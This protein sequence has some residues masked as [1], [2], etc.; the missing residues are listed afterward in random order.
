MKNRDIK[1]TDLLE[2]ANMVNSASI[3]ANGMIPQAVSLVSKRIA[4][5]FLSLLILLFFSLGNIPAILQA[6]TVNG[7][8]AGQTFLSDEEDIVVTRA[9]TY[10]DLPEGTVDVSLT[11]DGSALPVSIGITELL[12]AGWS[13]NSMV[14]TCGLDFKPRA[15]ATGKLE[16][17]W[18]MSE[19]PQMPFTV[20][21]RVNTSAT[22]GGFYKWNGEIVWASQTGDPA[23]QPI[24]GEDVAFAE[25]KG[26]D[27]VLKFVRK[28]KTLL[29]GFVGTLYESEDMITWAPVEGATS[30]CSVDIANGSSKYYRAVK[31]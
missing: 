9:F 4:F 26:D 13:F 31:Q 23:I 1:I 24:E 28:G 25:L 21:Y 20:I 19:I 30:P 29:L 15:G 7:E 2:Q 14:E 10:E 6:G 16:F 27:P 18:F 12:P 22:T 3:C 5:R 8:D 11:F 17:V